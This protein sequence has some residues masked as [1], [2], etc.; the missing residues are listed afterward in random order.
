MALNDK[1]LTIITAVVLAAGGGAASLFLGDHGDDRPELVVASVQPAAPA[2]KSD[3]RVEVSTDREGAVVASIAPDAKAAKDTARADLVT[4]DVLAQAPELADISKITQIVPTRAW[5]DVP[6]PS[7]PRVST[8]NTDQMPRGDVMFD[9]PVAPLVK[10]APDVRVTQ[11]TGARVLLKVTAACHSNS[12]VLIEHGGLRFKEKLDAEGK[13]S[14]KVP[15][16]AEFSRF[17][18]TLS[19]GTRAEVGAYIAG[20]SQVDRVGISW[21]GADDMFLHG[22]VG[23]AAWGEETHVWRLNA[24]SVSTARMFGGGY[25]VTLGNPNLDRPQLAQVFTLPHGGKNAGTFASVEVESLR[26]DVSCGGS[27]RLRTA[28]HTPQAGNGTQAVD[29]SLP[30]C[31]GDADSLTLKNLF[32]D[33]KVAAR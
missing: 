6:N 2:P 5:A 22:Y 33:M 30:K 32:K 26:G 20:L 12:E 15:V 31:G 10:C 9:Q 13:L 29:V 18:I 21:S 4:I 14:L 25:L 1:M 3:G 8:I 28:Q 11:L 16:F 17:N 19:D 24:R 23:G 7:L 27:L